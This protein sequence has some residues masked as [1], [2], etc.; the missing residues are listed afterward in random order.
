[1]TLLREKGIHTQVH[2][3]PVHLQP[4]YRQRFN[5]NPGDCPKAE[6]YYSKCLSIPLYPAMSDLAVLRVITEIKELVGNSAHR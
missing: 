1:M 6:S 3:I 5:T 2:Y 4:F